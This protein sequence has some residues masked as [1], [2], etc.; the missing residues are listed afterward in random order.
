MLD[1]YQTKNGGEIQCAEQRIL[2]RVEGYL[3]SF[4]EKAERALLCV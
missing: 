4:R 1:H 2:E 3:L